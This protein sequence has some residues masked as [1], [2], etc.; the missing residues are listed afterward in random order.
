MDNKKE[1]V[2]KKCCHL[3][4]QRR[5]Q[6]ALH[7]SIPHKEMKE[8]P[9]EA[10]TRPKSEYVLKSKEV[11]KTEESSSFL[12]ELALFVEQRKEREKLDLKEEVLEQEENRQRWRNL[13]YITINQCLSKPWVSS[14]FRHIPLRIYCL[15]LGN[16]PQLQK[17]KKKR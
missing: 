10:Q 17:K 15:P 5:K 1:T 7:T 4:D 12:E 3:Q 9:G 16:R 11:I 8:D 13:H 14:Y 2:K 6:F